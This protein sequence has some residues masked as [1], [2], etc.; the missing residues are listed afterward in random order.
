MRRPNNAGIRK[1]GR[2]PMMRSAENSLPREA[3]GERERFANLKLAF[4]R[5]QVEARAA[6]ASDARAQAEE[7]LREAA[8]RRLA[9][10][11]SVRQTLERRERA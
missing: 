1:H 2:G 3:E 10:E 7:R 9:A 6:I 4:S 5:A 11:A 8:E